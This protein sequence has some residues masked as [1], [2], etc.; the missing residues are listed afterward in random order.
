MLGGGTAE[1][2]KQQHFYL[3]VASVLTLIIMS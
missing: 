3:Q 2:D 1:T